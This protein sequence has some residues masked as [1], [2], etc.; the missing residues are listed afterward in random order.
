MWSRTQR[1]EE[2]ENAH[3][4]HLAVEQDLSGQDELAQQFV[5]GAER[6]SGAHDYLDYS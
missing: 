1:Q 4:G 3:R 5:A 2:R 6:D